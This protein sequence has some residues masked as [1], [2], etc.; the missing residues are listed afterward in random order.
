M[1]RQR[2]MARGR[3]PLHT[4]MAGPMSTPPPG[5]SPAPL[6]GTAAPPAIRI[7]WD[8]GTVPEWYG[9]LAA[10]PRSTLTQGFGYSAAQFT[11]E[12]WKPRLGIIEL[13]DKPIGLVVVTEKRVLGLI[14]VVRLHRGPLLRPEAQ[15]PAVY[16]AVL[17]ALRQAYPSGPLRWTAIVPEL[18][19]TDENAALLRWAGWTRV[20]GPGYR[21]LWLDLRADEAALRAGLAQKWRNALHQAERAGLTVEIDRDGAQQL[22]WLLEQ[23]AKD[24]AAKGYRGPSARLVTRLRTAMHKDGDILLLRALQ[25]GQPVAGVLLLGHGKAATY[26][27]GWTG[28]EGRRSRAHN[29]LLWRAALELK[30]QGRL[31]FDLGGILPE[32]A[33]GVTAFKRGMG[34]EEVELVG[35]WR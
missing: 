16:A 24:R 8:V 35:V 23:Y 2:I 34:G 10:C 14:R 19:A 11:V 4:P 1:A 22:G 12:G 20:K 32:Q 3:V 21:T 30:R 5:P 27:I 6:P 25:D 26:Q 29:L 9:L 17:K 13:A 18:P 33:P 7:V 15:K 28:P 31:W